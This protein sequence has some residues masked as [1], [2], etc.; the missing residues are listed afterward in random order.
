MA[1]QDQTLTCEDCSQQFT[2]TAEEQDFYA[3][4][5]YT[6]SPKRCKPCRDNRKSQKRT[7]RQMYPAICAQCQKECQVPF[8]PKPN[9]KPVLCDVCFRA[10][11]QN[12]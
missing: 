6:N 2:W 12:A 8:E 7:D 10:T 4:K 9:G 11:R 5:G 1:F 3:Q